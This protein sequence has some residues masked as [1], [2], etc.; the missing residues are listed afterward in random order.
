MDATDPRG[1]DPQVSL[2]QEEAQLRAWV[3]KI[4]AHLGQDHGQGLRALT[5]CLRRGYTLLFPALRRLAQEGEESPRRALVQAIGEA[6]DPADPFRAAFLLELL[7]PL[8]WDPVPEIRRAARR[9][10][11]EKLLAVYPGEALEA[12]VQWA[13]EPEA[14]R[15]ALAAQM[16]GHVPPR[17]ARRA[18]IALKPLAHS[19]EP[20]VRRAVLAALRRLAQTAPEPVNAELRRWREDPGLAPIAQRLLDGKEFAQR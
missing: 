4:C 7:S 14:A 6:A 3:E 18:L 1:P 12:L 10:L 13:A 2:L 8:L 9:T 15:Q 16:L 11:R 17:A 5:E 20:R 19:R